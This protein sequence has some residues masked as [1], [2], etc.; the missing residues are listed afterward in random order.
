[1]GYATI[2][3]NDFMAVGAS[4]ALA[5]LATPHHGCLMRFI[6]DESHRKELIV[7]HFLSGDPWLLQHDVTALFCA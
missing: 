5:C 6:L 2:D 4:Q 1:M 3:L 7:Y